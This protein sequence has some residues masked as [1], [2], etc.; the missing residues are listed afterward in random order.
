MPAERRDRFVILVIDN[1]DIA[2]GEWYRSHA[3]VEHQQSNGGCALRNRC[4]TSLDIVASFHP[5]PFCT[6]SPAMVAVNWPSWNRSRTATG[7][8]SRGRTPAGT[9]SASRGGPKKR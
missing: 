6:C 2:L 1:R 3:D 4:W 7:G 8:R 5:Q 9:W